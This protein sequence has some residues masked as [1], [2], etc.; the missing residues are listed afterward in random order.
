MKQEPASLVCEQCKNLLLQFHIFKENVKN[1]SLLA[2]IENIKK[3]KIFLDE[4]ENEKVVCLRYNKCLTLV[5]ESKKS[6]MEVFQHWQPQVVIQLP[7]SRKR[8]RVETPP[9]DE[10]V[11]SHIEDVLE[12][13]VV[14]KKEE[15]DKMEVLGLEDESQ[16]EAL[17]EEE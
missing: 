12:I 7:T 2:E 14:G 8:R 5:P 13:E 9:L 4:N 17:T 1:N 16:A 11:E 10:T 15:A 3:V 6:F